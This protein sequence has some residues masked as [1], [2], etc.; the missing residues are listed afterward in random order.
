[1]KK[2]IHYENREFI[3]QSARK[4]KKIDYL[5]LAEEDYGTKEYLFRYDLAKARIKFKERSN[6]MTTCKVHYPSDRKNL[7]SVFKCP[8]GECASLDTL[9]HWRKCQPYEHLRE[10]RNLNDDYDLLS[11]YQD[12]ISLRQRDTEE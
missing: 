7:E 2:I 3:I 8:E 10:N 12:V 6:C 9:S 5:S 1:M 4:Y 11:Y